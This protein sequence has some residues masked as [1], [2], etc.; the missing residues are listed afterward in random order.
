MAILVTLAGCTT[1]VDQY[2]SHADML[3]FSGRQR[4]VYADPGKPVDQSHVD[5]DIARSDPWAGVVTKALDAHD[6]EARKDTLQTVE[7]VSRNRG[8]YYG[9]SG[10]GAGGTYSS[11]PT[12]N[13]PQH[14]LIVNRTGHT[15]LVEMIGPTTTTVEVPAQ[16]WTNVTALPGNYN[17]RVRDRFGNLDAETV[18]VIN[19]VAND[20]WAF[21]GINNNRLKADWCHIIR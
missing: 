14:G 3:T 11:A 9:G 2:G 8:G 17:F 16:G 21:V 12:A 19:E 10:Y 20:D 7:Q 18:G 13:R 15:W 4:M 1:T 6:P 5:Q